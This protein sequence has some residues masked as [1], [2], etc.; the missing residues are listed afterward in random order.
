[1]RFI[2]LIGVH[3][4]VTQGTIP[5]VLILPVVN[6][7]Y[8]KRKNFIVYIVQIYIEYATHKMTNEKKN[9]KTCNQYKVENYSSF[10]YFYFTTFCTFSILAL[11]S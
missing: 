6:Y 1:M 7:E 4:Q 10:Y 11:L 9:R 8:M 5:T 3:A 2:N